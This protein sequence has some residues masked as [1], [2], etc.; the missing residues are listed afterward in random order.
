MVTQRVFPD[1]FT[2]VKKFYYKAPKAE[3]IYPEE[4]IKLEALNRHML[5]KDKNLKNKVSMTP[6]YRTTDP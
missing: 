6:I 3:E 2:A 4:L 1:E 5:G